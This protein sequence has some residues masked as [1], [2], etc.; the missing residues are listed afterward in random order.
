[1]Y[2]AI[3]HTDN[4]GGMA[5]W[6]YLAIVGLETGKYVMLPYVIPLFLSAIIMGA[7]A[8]YSSSLKSV[9]GVR[10][11]RISIL[12]TSLWS[13]CYA[14]ELLLPTVTAKQIASNFAFMAIAALPV[15]WLDTVANFS[16]FGRK[17]ARLVPFLVV[18]PL[19]TTLIIWTNPWH[20]LFIQRLSLDSNGT[21]PILKA[22]YGLWFWVHSIYTYSLFAISIGLLIGLMVRT[23][24]RYI[25]QPLTLLIGML[26]PLVWN[27]L[28]VF[29]VLPYRRL[30]LTPYLYSL[31]GIVFWIGLVYAY[32]FDVLPVA[33]DMVMDAMQD[34]VV[35]IDFQD[36]VV[37]LNPAAR[38][39]FSWGERDDLISKPVG[40]VFSKWPAVLTLL[41]DK[42]SNS[43][44]L[45]LV[46]QRAGKRYHYQITLVRLC[47]SQGV[48]IGRMLMLHD[49]TDRKQ[50][51]E[52]LRRLVVT[53]PLTE[54]G[55]RRMFFNALEIEFA[56]AK[57][58]QTGYC[59]IMLDLDRF[60]SINDRF[61]HMVGDEALKLAA[62]AIRKTAR[63]SDLAARY[64]GDEFVL[65][66][67]NTTLQ[68]AVQLAER[69]RKAIN[70]CQLSVG[71]R[72]TAS[73][74]VAAFD[75]G[76]KSSEDLLLRVDH[77][78]YHAKENNLGISTAQTA[79]RSIST[80]E[81]S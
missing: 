81:Q 60:K 28:Y 6:C 77:A 20:H 25:G 2:N 14:L 69:L 63:Q 8:W 33:R 66:L 34:V 45:D 76:D 70:Q 18:I 79:S 42:K 73:A 29:G 13:L 21:F 72:L 32:L 59:L 23:S 64:G 22:E 11:F 49:I 65:L 56:R 74:G 3:H 38:A 47:D 9:P 24:K 51:E 61:S 1:M 35:I 50:M 78:L 5:R 44:P 15:A 19:L 57:R 46:L 68:G 10:G 26:I 80:I 31:S 40:Q 41:Q 27:V 55:N 52:E 48:P 71:E 58:Y 54:L 30:D 4:F 53:D 36:R 75:P 12:I 62:D 16:G 39:V 43:R 67:P 37:D 17:F 7:L